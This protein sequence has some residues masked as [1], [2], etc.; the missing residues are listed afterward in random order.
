M[1]LV[2]REE[3]AQQPR[4]ASVH[5]ISG[6]RECKERFAYIEPRP[7]RLPSSVGIPPVTLLPTRY[8]QSE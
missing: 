1:Q 7:E 8:L 5:T 3:A 6:K 2:V 4:H